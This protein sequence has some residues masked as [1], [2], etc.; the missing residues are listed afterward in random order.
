V[1]ANTKHCPKCQ[2]AIEKNHGCNHMMCGAP[3]YHQFCWLC[4]GSWVNHSGGSFHCNRYAADKSEFTGD[5][6]RER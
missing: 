5:K 2:R 1:L 3:C 6:T 4:L